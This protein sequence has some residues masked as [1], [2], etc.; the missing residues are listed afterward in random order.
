MILGFPH[1]TDIIQDAIN[2]NNLQCDIIDPEPA[3]CTT[4]TETGDFDPMATLEEV[5]E[6]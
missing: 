1:S 5:G 6:D 4:E 3:R 2:D